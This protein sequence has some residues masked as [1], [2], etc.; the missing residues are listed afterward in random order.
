MEFNDTMIKVVDKQYFKRFFHSHE[1]AYI[2]V[3]KK[4][5]IQNEIEFKI[6]EDNIYLQEIQAMNIKIKEHNE[7]Y[8]KL[9]NT[10]EIGLLNLK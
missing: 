6:K 7:K 10:L 3:Y 8:E 4:K 1:G 2:L 5:S 9:K